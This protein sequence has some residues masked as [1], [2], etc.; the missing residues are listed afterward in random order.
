MYAIVLQ[1]S[2]YGFG[3][4]L[5][6]KGLDPQSHLGNYHKVARFWLFITNVITSFSHCRPRWA[7]VGYRTSV[8]LEAEILAPVERVVQR[9]EKSS[10]K[11]REAINGSNRVP[12]AA[13]HAERGL[14]LVVYEI[15]RGA[16]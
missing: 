4:K 10:G 15:L 6:D 9:V 11:E 16:L 5:Q 13:L 12:I 14:A 1:T 8:A 2:Y 7:L 3:N